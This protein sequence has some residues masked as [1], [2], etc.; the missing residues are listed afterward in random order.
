MTYSKAKDLL[1]LADFASSR[2][3]GVTLTD[4]CETFEV[5][6]RTAQ[7]MTAALY[8][9][10]PLAVEVV[11]DES[12]Q[13]RWI[14]RDVPLARLRL[15]GDEEL[16]GLE[17]AISR[18]RDTGDL[19]QARALASLR[20]RLVAALPPREARR[21]EADA[22][23]MLEVHGVAARPGPIVTVD[24]QVVDAV[25]AALR[26]PYRL[27]FSYNDSERL[28]EP[29]GILLG[30]RRYLVAKQ[31]DK[32]SGLRYFRLDRIRAP[33]VTDEW[34]ARDAG[35]DLAEHAARSFGS[36]QDDSQFAEIIWRFAPEAADRAAEWRF[37]PRQR[38]QRTD[39]GGFEVRFE[40]SGW[41]EMAWHLYQWGDAVTVVEP[42]GLADLVH[43]ARRTDFDALP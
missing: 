12:R 29:Y 42:K 1:R 32:G 34:F 37:H 3:R 40:A 28:V 5:S 43:P 15:S 10:F 27:H 21:A 13:R 26:G 30:A 20:D 24:P 14:I 39:D 7:R 17:F 11:E 33:I 4:I 2:F 25:T 9:V 19:R 41:L 22:E 6:H 18:M 35:F 8:D 36:F 23:A 38:A 31:P 16:E